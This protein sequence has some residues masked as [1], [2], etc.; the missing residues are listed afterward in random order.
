M[1]VPFPEIDPVLIQI[2]PFAIRW[3]ALAYIAGLL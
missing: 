3:Y 1:P 2:G